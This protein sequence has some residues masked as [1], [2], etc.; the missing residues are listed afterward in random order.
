MAEPDVLPDLF[1]G[2]L[3]PRFLWLQRLPLHLASGTQSFPPVVGLSDP[4][5]SLLPWTVCTSAAFESKL[6]L[7]FRLSIKS[8]AVMLKHNKHIY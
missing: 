4:P 6:R 7:S 2:H 5:F 1:K 3:R 8:K